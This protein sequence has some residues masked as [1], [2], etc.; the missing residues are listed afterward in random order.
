[1][2]SGEDPDGEP[3]IDDD[4][5]EVEVA[6]PADDPVVPPAPAPE[7]PAPTP[8][9]EPTPDEVLGIV[10]EPL[11]YTGSDARGLGFIGISLI[12]AGLLFLLVGARWLRREDDEEQ[13]D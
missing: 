9:P 7:P 5:V 10:D 3:V 13:D 2:A 4:I 11:A 12:V 8:T 6:E 1:M